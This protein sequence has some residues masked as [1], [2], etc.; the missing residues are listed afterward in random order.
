MKLL[1]HLLIIALAL[2]L[3]I[4]SVNATFEVEV[5]VEGK[6][7]PAIKF[8]TAL[9]DLYLPES[10][11]LS[12][13]RFLAQKMPKALT[14]DKNPRICRAKG[15]AGP[16]CCKKNCVNVMTDRLNCGV[17]GKKCKYMETCCRGQCV[18]LAFDKKHCG[19]CNN[20]CNKGDFCTYG[21]CN[22]A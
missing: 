10:Q 1:K 20:R 15:S 9:T 4:A 2:A 18:N 22:Y 5:E 7:E 19:R 13:R 8:S 6:E 16:D 14:C 11:P 3:V 17:C 12:L 21:L